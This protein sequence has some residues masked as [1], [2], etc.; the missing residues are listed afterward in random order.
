MTFL[1]LLLAKNHCTAFCVKHARQIGEHVNVDHALQSAYSAALKGA[2]DDFFTPTIS[3][4]H[5]TA[6]CVKTRASDRE[7]VNV[8]HTFET[9][10]SAALKRAIDDFSTPAISGEMAV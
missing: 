7:H 2:I 10:Y 8:D 3:S 9:V 6:F 1:R 4:N 5:G